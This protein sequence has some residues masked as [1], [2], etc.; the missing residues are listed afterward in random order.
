MS[1]DKRDG[2]EDAFV[3]AACRATPAVP[4]TIF[5]REKALF[6]SPRPVAKLVCVVL[7]ALSLRMER[8]SEE[9]KRSRERE[10]ASKREKKNRGNSDG[11][12]RES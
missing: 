2:A 3:A 4:A 5:L 10:T 6:L 11:G 8:K 9:L 7:F 12:E 1:L